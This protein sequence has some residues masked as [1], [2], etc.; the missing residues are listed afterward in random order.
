M[1]KS[2]SILKETLANEKRIIL[3]PG[4]IKSFIEAGYDVYVEENAGLE[5]GLTNREYE[6]EGATIVNV[7][8]AW[9][10]SD[11][12]IKYKAPTENEYKYFREGLTISAIFHAEGNQTL[13]KKMCEGKIT[14]YSYEFFETE[15]GY[16]PLA[17]SGGEIAG[18][19]AFLKAA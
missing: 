19:I 13:V 15:D 10:Y 7:E 17:M 4:H 12:I 1:K 2:I 3:L 14:A 18:K 6:K 9:T 8:Q 16:F 5:I 11:V